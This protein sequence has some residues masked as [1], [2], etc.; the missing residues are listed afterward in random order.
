MDVSCSGRSRSNFVFDEVL[1]MGSLGLTWC[2]LFSCLPWEL[3]SLFSIGNKYRKG[4][5]AGEL[6]TTAFR[7]FRLTFFAIFIQHI[8]PWVVSSP[9]DVRSWLIALGGFALMFP[10]FMR[11]PFKMPEY[12][13]MLIKIL[14]YATGV[15]MLL[16]I[17][18]ADG[19]TFSLGYSNIIILVLANM[20]IFRLTDLY[21][22]DQ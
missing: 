15:F 1:Y 5:S 12:V 6:Y 16:N 3:P 18:Y 9:Q 11:I 8:Y 17:N 13:R 7:G 22:N 19:R 10:M 14:A 2:F 20:A 21:I 4:S